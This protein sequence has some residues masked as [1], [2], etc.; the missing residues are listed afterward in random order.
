MVRSPAP[1]LGCLLLILAATLRGCSYEADS[2]TYRPIVPSGT[3]QL[4]ATTPVIYMQQVHFGT[5]A[6]SFLAV[7]QQNGSLV[8]EFKTG[9]RIRSSPTVA[10]NIIFFGSDD[11]KV[12]ALNARGGV[13]VW[14]FD[15]NASVE[16]CPYVNER[17]DMLYFGASNGKMYAVDVEDGKKIWEYQ[18]GGPVRSSAALSQNQRF[19]QVMVTWHGASMHPAQ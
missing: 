8:W 6:G 2:W 10:D 5:D 1:V 11:G 13:K 15:A 7:A 19:N 9:A 17:L 16:T 12:Y 14:E 18:T 3:E 4:I